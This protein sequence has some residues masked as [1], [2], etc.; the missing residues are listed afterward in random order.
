MQLL[1]RTV[2]NKFLFFIGQSPYLLQT[3]TNTNP[4]TLLSYLIFLLKNSNMAL[5]NAKEQ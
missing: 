4:A 5:T 1:Q 3:N 2:R